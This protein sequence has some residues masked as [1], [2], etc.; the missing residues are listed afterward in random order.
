MFTQL[1]KRPLPFSCWVIKPCPL[2]YS[3]QTTLAD[4][5]F[6]AM[7]PSQWDNATSGSNAYPSVTSTGSQ[8]DTTIKA[9][10]YPVNNP[11]P[12]PTPTSTDTL[13]KALSIPTLTPSPTLKQGHSSMG[14]WQKNLVP[15]L[16]MRGN[17][18]KVL[19]DML[20]HNDTGLANIMSTQAGSIWAGY[21]M[22]WEKLVYTNDV[23]LHGFTDHGMIFPSPI[24]LVASLDTQL[25]HNIAN[26]IVLE[27]EGLGIN[28]V[29]APV[30]EL[31]HKLR[32]G[33]VEENFGEL[34][35]LT[36]EMGVYAPL[37]M[38]VSISSQS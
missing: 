16:W 22:P 1:H 5:F 6:L 4:T 32:W 33:R 26:I 34:L 17:E 36:G 27:A 35:F 15:T 3:K 10:P 7:V 28:H 12:T 29:F 9:H 30:L 21:E 14:A 37:N 2:Q 19:D 18:T 13:P 8:S 20:V 11:I 25:I 38:P 24:S 31:S 23:G